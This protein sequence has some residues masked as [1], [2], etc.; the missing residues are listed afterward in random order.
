MIECCGNEN[1]SPYCPQCGKQLY[2]PSVLHEILLH[3]QQRMHE[4]ERRRKQKEQYEGHHESLS[5]S[6][7][8]WQRWAQALSEAIDKDR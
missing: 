4:A 2:A 5:R 8:K 3:C 6:Y 1:E 7:L